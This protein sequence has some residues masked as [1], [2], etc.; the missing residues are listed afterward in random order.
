MADEYDGDDASAKCRS[1]AFGKPST[2]RWMY[3]PEEMAEKAARVEHFRRQAAAGKDLAIDGVL[4]Q[5]TYD[6]EAEKRFRN[7]K[8]TEIES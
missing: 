2:P 7:K 4:S 8:G 5:P 3:Y 1:K 6:D